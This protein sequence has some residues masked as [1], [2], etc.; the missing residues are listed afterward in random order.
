MSPF[1]RYVGVQFPSWILAA[2]VVWGL[3]H[4]MGLRW[5]WSA[6]LLLAYVVKDFLLYPLLRKAY[7]EDGRSG[8]EP[9][10]G[11]TGIVVEE[12]NPSGYVRVRGELW[13]AESTGDSIPAGVAVRVVSAEGM[14][15][16]VKRDQ[17]Q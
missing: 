15:L 3:H 4:W 1:Q 5:A 17:K 12:L 8:A 14:T 6:A 7:E 16:T 10:V 9:L 13:R 2:V 11:R